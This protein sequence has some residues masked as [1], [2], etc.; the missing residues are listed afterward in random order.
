MLSLAA[1][2]MA[3][4][5]VEIDEKAIPVE[6]ILTVVAVLAVVVWEI[7]KKACG[8]RVKKVQ[9]PVEE[10]S[11]ERKRLQ[12]EAESSPKKKAAAPQRGRRCGRTTG[13]PRDQERTGRTMDLAW[14]GVPFP[15]Q[16]PRPNKSCRLRGKVPGARFGGSVPCA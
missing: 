13:G 15:K 5:V 3:E 14:T 6:L 12:E 10:P 8:T 16:A 7:T 11:Q 4:E 1:G 9:G 2:A